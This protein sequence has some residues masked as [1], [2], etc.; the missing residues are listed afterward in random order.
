MNNSIF[1]PSMS[2]N[3]PLPDEAFDAT[4]YY[5]IDRLNDMKGLS[6]IIVMALWTIPFMV[7][8]ITKDPHNVYVNTNSKYWIPGEL[9]SYVHFR[10]I[11]ITVAVAILVLLVALVAYKLLPTLMTYMNIVLSIIVPSL[12]IPGVFFY[13]GMNN[14]LSH[15]PVEFVL[16]C[17][18]GSLIAVHNSRKFKYDWHISHV[19]FNASFS[20]FFE[21][22]IITLPALI[23]LTVFILFV[24]FGLRCVVALNITQFPQPTPALLQ[25]RGTFLF[26]MIS[27]L[28]VVFQALLTAF[29]SAVISNKFHKSKGLN[30]VEAFIKTFSYRLGSSA[31]AVQDCILNIFVGAA[32]VLLKTPFSNTVC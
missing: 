11:A 12:F 22:L 8:G 10:I 27:L 2:I 32:S 3:I 19:V 31:Y 16:A 6:A 18:V 21:S 30:P 26:I 29:V 28:S 15:H 23:L 25:V 7:M 14:G 17:V 13:L 4:S 20:I 1:I 24:L 9:F 5:R